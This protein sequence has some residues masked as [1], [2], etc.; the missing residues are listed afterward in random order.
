M[1]VA[2]SAAPSKPD[3]TG[4]TKQTVRTPSDENNS[5][6]SENNGGDPPRRRKLRLKPRS[7]PLSWAQLHIGARLNNGTYGIIYEYMVTTTNAAGTRVLQTRVDPT[8]VVKGTISQVANEDCMRCPQTFINEVEHHRFV[9]RV[10]RECQYADPE[11]ALTTPNAGDGPFLVDNHCY[12]TMERLY[13]A[14]I[15]PLTDKLGQFHFQKTDEAHAENAVYDGY[16][17]G[18]EAIQNIC[19]DLGTTPEKIVRDMALFCGVCYR[20][21]CLPLDVEYTVGKVYGGSPRVFVHDF[22]K[23]V[24]NSSV[25]PEKALERLLT[26]LSYPDDGEWGQLF[27]STF[28]TVCTQLVGGELDFGNSTTP[29]LE[30]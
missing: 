13:P 30:F 26:Q 1:S 28:L 4:R 2:R 19:V 7:V 12:Y 11:F 17:F 9:T 3:R 6:N 8:R 20:H 15:N 24:T 14:N 10:I 16:E 5:G 18:V 27:V 21:G 29:K 23:I 22:D 25:P